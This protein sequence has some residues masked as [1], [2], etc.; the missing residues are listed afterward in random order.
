MSDAKPT[1]DEYLEDAVRSL[2]RSDN[3]EWDRDTTQAAYDAQVQVVLLDS[4][5]SG[6]IAI[7][8]QLKGQAAPQFVIDTL[9]MPEE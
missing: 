1:A 5:A 3:V 8:L 2:N 6:I 4:I 9:L 7:A